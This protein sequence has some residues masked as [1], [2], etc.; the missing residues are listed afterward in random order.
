MLSIRYAEKNRWIISDIITV[1][2]YV[3]GRQATIYSA[4][5]KGD[6]RCFLSMN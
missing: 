3:A 1:K 4:E 6:L 2:D 5:A